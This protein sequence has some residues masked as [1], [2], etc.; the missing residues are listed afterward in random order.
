MTGRT[1]RVTVSIVHWN[2]GE[3]TLA[4]IDSVFAERLP[5]LSIVLV[6]NAST[7]GI[8]D[9]VAARW[10]EVTVVRKITNT[11][12][13]GGQNAGIDAA[14][15]AGA[16]YVLLLNQDALLVPGC[17][18]RM[19]ALA[20]ADSRTGLVSPLVYYA[21]Q[22]SRVQFAGSWLLPDAMDVGYDGDLAVVKARDADPATTMCL[23]G[24][25]LLIRRQVVEAIGVLDPR[26]FAYF[27][28]TDYSVRAAR[29]GWRNRMC[30]DAG[31]L[32][33]GH[34]TRFTRAP[35][36]FYFV[37]RNEMMFWRKA[38]PAS[39]FFRVRRLC[40]ARTL[41]E[42]AKLRDAGLDAQVAA[43]MSGLWDAFVGRVGAYDATRRAPRWWSWALMR[44]PY[45]VADLL[46]GRVGRRARGGDQRWA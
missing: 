37:S 1:P 30:F 6:D 41:R 44:H 40:V 24:T 14:M 45:F 16:D 42:A 33:E 32:H 2:G 18:G 27:E 26:L 13:T 28:D 10:P 7:D 9:V 35:N 43:C 46:E 31:I 38:M 21:D 4:C 15:A 11:G 29:A 20:E 12:F 3:S 23:W 36:F 22:P 39:A 17:I 25:A 5:D 34:P 19:V 8:A